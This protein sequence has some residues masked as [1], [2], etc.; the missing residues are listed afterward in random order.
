MSVLTIPQV[1]QLGEASIFLS[2]NYQ[3]EGSIYGGRLLNNTSPEM[4]AIVTDAVKWEYAG[5]PS[6]SNVSAVGYLVIASVGADGD[7]VEIFALIPGTGSV[8]LGT[9][10]KQSSDTTTT[11][12]A[13]SIAA[14]LS[15]YG[16]SFTSS[17]NSVAITAPSSLGSTINGGTNLIAVFTT[18]NFLEINSTDTLLINTTDKFI[19]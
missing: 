17:A 3:A 2:G 9:Y 13:T 16:F 12:L 1:I 15:G 5:N 11:I 14:A 8:S 10:I 19:I 18:N 7:S 4:I 6:T